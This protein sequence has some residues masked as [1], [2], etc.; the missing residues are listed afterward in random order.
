MTG[1][2]DRT[3]L[4]KHP[5]HSLEKKKTK[6]MALCKDRDEKEKKKMTLTDVEYPLWGRCFR[7]CQHGVHQ[8][9][10][11]GD[12][13]VEDDKVGEMFLPAVCS[14]S[15]EMRRRLGP[16]GDEKETY[17]RSHSCSSNRRWGWGGLRLELPREARAEEPTHLQETDMRRLG[18]CTVWRRG[19]Q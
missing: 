2:I 19:D 1:G 17:R 18:C 15:S 3:V 13:T 6:G 10:W 9:G 4:T 5:C 14:S 7:R 12:E 11:T 8:L 16:Y